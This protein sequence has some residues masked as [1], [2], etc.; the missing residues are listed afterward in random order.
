MDIAKGDGEVRMPDGQ[1]RKAKL[2][3]QMALK[4]INN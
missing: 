3:K 2:R 1:N 4:Q